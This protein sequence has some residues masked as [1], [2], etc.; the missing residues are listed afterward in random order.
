MKHQRQRRGAG[1]CART[2]SRMPQDSSTKSGTVPGKVSRKRPD[3][4]SRAL[5]LRLWHST[6]WSP[7]SSNRSFV[8]VPINSEEYIVP[9]R[10]A[11]GS[12][13]GLSEITPAFVVMLTGRFTGVLLKVTKMPPS[14][15]G[16]QE[17]RG[18]NAKRAFLRA[19][20]VRVAPFGASATN[21]R[22]SIAPVAPDVNKTPGGE[23]R[24]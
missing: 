15:L 12:W 9:L 4:S 2:D 24:I 14:L 10:A 1:I 6:T 11:A 8:A 3:P 19:S 16:R 5:V 22:P 7:S 21:T 20:G 23:Q 13:A 18:P 17:R